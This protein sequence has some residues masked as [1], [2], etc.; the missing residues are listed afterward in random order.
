MPCRQK[1]GGRH[2]ILHPIITQPVQLTEHHCSVSNLGHTGKKPGLHTGPGG[3]QGI[4]HKRP[5]PSH[6]RRAAPSIR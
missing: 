3:G 1:Y 5:A 6:F 2:L 4:A